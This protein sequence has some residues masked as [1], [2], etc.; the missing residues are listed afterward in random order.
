MAALPKIEN[1]QASRGFEGIW[2]V[3][4]QRGP[5]CGMT[6]GG[7]FTVSIT[8]GGTI[9]GKG[10]AIGRAANTGAVSWNVPAATDGAPVRYQGTLRSTTGSGSFS[11]L[12]G[13]CVGSWSA[14]RG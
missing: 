8:L 10:G 9:L 2:T 12:D 14:K 4:W 13:R 11:R 7:S 6:G 1:P 5:N 3:V